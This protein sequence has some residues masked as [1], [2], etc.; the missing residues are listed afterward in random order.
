M[1]DERCRGLREEGNK[2]EMRV[3]SLKTVLYVN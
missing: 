1:R 3:E 2:G